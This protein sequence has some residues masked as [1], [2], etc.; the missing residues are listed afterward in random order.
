MAAA[1]PDQSAA[2]LLDQALAKQQLGDPEGALAAFD[3]LL[4]RFPGGPESTRA[5]VARQACVRALQALDPL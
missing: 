3:D 4:V 5:Q 1:D 2:G